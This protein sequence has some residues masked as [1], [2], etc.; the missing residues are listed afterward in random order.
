MNPALFKFPTVTTMTVAQWIAV[1]DN[2]WQRDTLKRLRTAV[3]KHLRDFFPTH[4]VV[5]AARVGRVLYKLDGHTRAKRW[6]S[7]GA[8][9]PDGKVLVI[10]FDFPDLASLDLTTSADPDMTP[11]KMALDPFYH[12]MD[13]KLAVETSKD[14]LAGAIRA[15]EIEPTAVDKDGLPTFNSPLLKSAGIA[16]GLQA[17]H[18]TVFQATMKPSGEGAQVYDIAAE[19]KP[20]IVLIEKVGASGLR[21]T[22]GY[23]SAMLI[24]MRRDGEDAVEF[25]TM[26]QANAGM[27]QGTRY[28][29]L[30]LLEKFQM[31]RRVQSEATK[32][33]VD[34]AVRRRTGSSTPDGSR[35]S[36]NDAVKS[37]QQVGLGLYLRWVADNRTLAVKYERRPSTMD[38]SNDKAISDL[39]AGAAAK[40]PLQTL[41]AKEATQRS[42]D[43][44][45]SVIQ[46]APFL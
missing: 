45:G 36:G 46:P 13:S 24:S 23:V 12:A 20:E 10:I 44:I 33:R 22:S 11:E 1:A 26:H 14:L 31:E 19:W 8:L 9:P 27:K 6:E 34:E 39:I 4:W 3:K 40:R 5:F 43:G 2:P 32:A 38:R 30:G 7:K 35:A 41:V 25:W 37:F 29:V 42:G 16:T 17:A 28:D 21:F 15:L 18:T